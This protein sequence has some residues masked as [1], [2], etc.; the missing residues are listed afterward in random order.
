MNMKDKDEEFTDWLISMALGVKPHGYKQCNI[1]GRQYP[2]NVSPIHTSWHL[3]KYHY[4]NFV[5]SVT[6]GYKDEFTPRLQRDYTLKDTLDMCITELKK[7]AR[8]A[9][10]E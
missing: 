5:E 10:L 2:L 9:G 3:Y 1:C 7:Y 6:A 8:D 4:E